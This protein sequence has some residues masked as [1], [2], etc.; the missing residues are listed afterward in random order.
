[1]NCLFLLY[2]NMEKEKH[3]LQPIG[4]EHNCEFKLSSGK[5]IDGN[6]THYNVT[7]SCSEMTQY[8]NHSNRSKALSR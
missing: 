2:A 7:L 4:W 1:M 6:P 5:E 3:P 8:L